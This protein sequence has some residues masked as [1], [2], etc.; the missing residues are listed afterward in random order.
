MG[1][2]KL[3]IVKL[4]YHYDAEIAYNVFM[5]YPKSC[6]YI[7]GIDEAGRGPLAGSVAVGAVL[8]PVETPMRK[9]RDV[10]DAKK[11]A[12]AR[13]IIF[14]ELLHEE[15]RKGNLTFSFASSGPQII[16]RIGIV[17]AIRYAISRA[18]L[19]FD[20]DPTQCLVLLDGSLK[21]PGKFVYQR[22]IIKGD[23]KIKIISLASV[24]AKVG[25][26]KKMV[27]L[28]RIF[29]EYG[30]ERHKGYGT[31]MHYK[32]IRKYGLCIIHRKS[33]IHI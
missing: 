17:K 15:Q 13:R 16:D 31:K 4:L 33:F 12:P 8:M 18:L 3:L 7:I 30:F 10:T 25:R 5:R 23:E 32:Q 14:L 20:V 11:L 28:A 24:V 26:D 27:R 21:A 22:T 9:F 1:W 2:T 29:P 6:K 19:Q